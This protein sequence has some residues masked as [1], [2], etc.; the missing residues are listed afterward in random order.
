LLFE[1]L[2][3]ETEAEAVVLLVADAGSMVLESLLDISSL[4]SS[5]PFLIDDADVDADAGATGEMKNPLLVLLLFVEADEEAPP[6]L[7]VSL[8]FWPG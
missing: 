4:V 1:Y 5:G 6:P 7:L 8:L 2:E 3:E